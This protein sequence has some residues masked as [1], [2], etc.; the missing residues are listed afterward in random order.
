MRVF[1]FGSNWQVFS[2][3]RVDA[4]RL[5]VAARS[6]QALLQR[7]T[8]KGVSVLDVGCGSGLFSIAAHQLGASKVVGVDVN[9]RC[10]AVSE[11]NHARLAPSAVMTF[12]EAS[13]L[14]PQSMQPLG[15]FDL[16]YAWGS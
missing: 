8:L 11:Q 15:L 3:Q 9:P 4:Q 1:D 7:D 5:A 14:S 12:Q 16:V 6:L 2:E 10:V 13:A